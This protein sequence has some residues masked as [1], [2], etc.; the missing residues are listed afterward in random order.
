MT[1]S[2]TAILGEKLNLYNSMCKRSIEIFFSHKLKAEIK[3]TAIDH[4]N[5]GK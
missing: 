4:S 2:K 1:L 3:Q 5:Y